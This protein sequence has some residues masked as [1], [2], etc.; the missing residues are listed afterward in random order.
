MRYRYGTKFMQ[1]SC[2]NQLSTGT[3]ATTEANMLEALETQIIFF[4]YTECKWL[5]YTKIR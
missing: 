3:I 5:Y 4:T 1:K 2:S